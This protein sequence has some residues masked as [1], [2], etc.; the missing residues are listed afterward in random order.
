[1]KLATTFFESAI[2]LGSPFEP[3]YYLAEIH[4]AEAQ[5][6]N[7][8]N[9]PYHVQGSCAMA[10][11][12][13]KAVA[14]R[15]AWDDDPVREG[16]AR[17]KSGTERAREDAMLRWWIASERGIEIAQNNIAFV[18]DQGTLSFSSKRE[19]MAIY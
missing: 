17:W 18:L 13:Y 15:G 10:V 19:W 6:P 4:A 1:M 2:R 12:F 5:N 7:S 11:N 8:K 16:E 3:Y 14:E 9:P